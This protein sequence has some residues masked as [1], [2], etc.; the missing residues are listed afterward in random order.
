MQAAHSEVKRKSAGKN[1]A[2]IFA[3]CGGEYK[4]GPIGEES[5]RIARNA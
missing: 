5:A 2:V 1:E 3:D 4:C